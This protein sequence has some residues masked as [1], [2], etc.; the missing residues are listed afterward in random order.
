MAGSVAEIIPCETC[1][2]DLPSGAIVCP[3]C[4]SVRPKARPDD[5]R[6]CYSC[7]VLAVAGVALLLFWV[8]VFLSQDL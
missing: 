6:P 3:R 8:V 2:E 1:G 7:R 4:G 5:S